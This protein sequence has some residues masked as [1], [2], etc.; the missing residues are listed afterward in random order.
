MLKI[1]RV[2]FQCSL[3]LRQFLWF[4]RLLLKGIWYAVAKVFYVA[5]RKCDEK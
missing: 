5:A 3:V 2:C 1:I 4:S